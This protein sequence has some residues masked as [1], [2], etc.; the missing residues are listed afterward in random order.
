MFQSGSALFKA[1]VVAVVAVLLLIPLGLLLGLVEERVQQRELAVHKVAQGWG[2]RQL[3]GG[4]VLAVPVTREDASERRATGELTR[5]DVVARLTTWEWYVLP[6]ELHLE[7]KLVVQDE[8]R[9]LGVY[10]VPVYVS[11]IRMTG[12]FE[13]A[14]AIAR[15]AADTSI[16][17][18]HVDRARLVLPL[19][20]VRGLRSVQFNGEPLLAANIEPV[21]GFPMQALGAP[22]R[23]DLALDTTRREFDLTLEVA[24]TE[25]FSML[26]LAR[27]V[28]AEMTGNWPHPGFSQGFLPVQHDEE[29]GTFQASWQILDLNRSFGSSW[30]SGALPTAQLESNAFGVQLVQPVDLYQ[31]TTRA[32]KYG[33]LFIALSLLTLFLWE[34]LTR[35]R[36]HPIQYGLMGLALSVFYL[37]LL[38][39]AEQIGFQ[40]AYTLAAL[41]LCVLLALY[42]AGAFR[43]NRA[44]STAGGIFAAVYALLYLLVTSEDYAL[45]AGSLALFG[46]LSTLMLLTRKLNWYGDEKE[47]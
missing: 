38:A 12:H 14:D 39:L 21:Q 42:L 24:G 20:D 4:P 34:N 30:F 8:P 31:R 16:K 10:E 7:T 47:A 3:I 33:G 32:V 44:G 19:S 45:L 25:A 18:V 1:A 13:L 15:L 26:P 28:R 37:L 41:A 9:R 6:E 35:R 23:K 40:L 5:E 36:L 2:G 43:S 22:L 11:T 17:Q 29:G 27:T 46:L